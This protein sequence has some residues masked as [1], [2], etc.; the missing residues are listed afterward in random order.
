[1]QCGILTIGRPGSSPAPTRLIMSATWV[2]SNCATSGSS[3]SVT[4]RYRGKIRH[5]AFDGIM[6][7]EQEVNDAELLIVAESRPSHHAR[8]STHT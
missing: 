4:V 7:D 8:S 3:D 2:L 5:A 1:M 6:I